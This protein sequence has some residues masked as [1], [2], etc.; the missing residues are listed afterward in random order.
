MKKVE[1]REKKRVFD[2]FFKID[3]AHLSHERFDGTMTP[4]M[5]RL[6]F[7]RG[8]SA[9]ALVWNR[10]SQKIILTEQFRYPT[11]EKGPG[12]ITEIAAGVLGKG[13]GPRDTARRE[14]LEETGYKTKKIEYI[15]TFYVSPGGTSERIILYYAEVTNQDKVS[16]GGGVAIEHEDIRVLEYSWPETRQLLEAGKIVDAKTLIALMWFRDSGKS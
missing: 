15:N 6:C 12:W 9:A 13:E 8:D 11:Y 5:R 4:V 10:E 2:D 16:E 14:I 1:I 3:E 7:E